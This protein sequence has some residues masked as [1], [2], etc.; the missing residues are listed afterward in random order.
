MT[1]ILV[2]LA[3][4]IT[5]LLLWLSTFYNSP[6]KALSEIGGFNNPVTSGIL[7][8]LILM[9]VLGT[10]LIWEEKWLVGSILILITGLVAS[11]G[12]IKHSP[13]KPKEIGFITLWGKPLTLGT[14]YFTVIGDVFLLP[15][16]PF[17]LTTIK[18]EVDNAEKLFEGEDFIFQTKDGVFMTI[19]ISITASPDV[20]DLIDYIQAGA[21]TEK[22]FA[23]IREIFYRETQKIVRDI[24]AEDV[25]KQ[26]NI[27]SEKLHTGLLESGSF[28][29]EIK[30]IQILPS[31]PAKYRE[32]KEAIKEE[33]LE[34]KAEQAEYETMRIAAEEIQLSH[35]RQFVPNIDN[36]SPMEKARK[37]SELIRAKEIPNLEKCLDEVKALR[38]IR[39]GKSLRIEGNG[40]VITDAKFNMGGGKP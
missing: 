5:A 17:N 26:G 34:R 23:Q 39:D 14:R 24:E 3:L 29:I 7:G 21:A 11:A 37:I 22:I 36:L 15:F 19:K 2:I 16:F 8:G 4:L 35:A 25:Q 20:T 28:G 12:H 27:V 30:K 1:L 33:E 31:L 18:I 40:V 6:N 9:L 38:Q 13:E 32:R 10:V